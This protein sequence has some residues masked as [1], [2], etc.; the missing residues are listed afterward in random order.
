MLGY[1]TAFTCIFFIDPKVESFLTRLEN[2]QASKKEMLKGAAVAISVSFIGILG[3]TIALVEMV[4]NEKY[5]LP[6]DIIAN[7]VQCK[8]GTTYTD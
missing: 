4:R 2:K 8:G 3:V 1:W 6:A 5:Q 7:Y